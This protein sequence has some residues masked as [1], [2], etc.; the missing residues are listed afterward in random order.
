MRSDRLIHTFSIVACDPQTGEIGVAVASKFLAVGSIVPW[1]KANVGAVAT[2]S[3][4]NTGFGPDGL[5][6]LAEGKTA[7]ETLELLLE[8]D[9]DRDYRQVGIV[10][11][12]GN[13][14]AFTGKK[15]HDYAFHHIGEGFTCQGNLLAGPEVLD[16]MAI[17]FQYAKGD[18]ADRLLAALIA[19][20]EAGGD[21]RG[22][23]GAALYVVKE[24]GAYD[25]HIDRYVDLRVDD[26]SSPT[27]E[28]KRLLNLHRLYMGE[29]D[30][31]KLRPI[32]GEVL[33]ELVGHLTRFD[34]LKA[35][36]EFTSYDETVKKALQDY[37][38]VENFDTRWREDGQI[39]EEILAFMRTK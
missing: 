19:G 13:A 6:L 29:T 35:D 8:G 38:A 21:K 23:Q 25:G 9:E 33:V 20:D 32:E 16:A 34:F 22:K 30:P 5:K 18:L 2:Q 39:D 37:C 3:W 4:A 12:H 17:S 7:R 1:A 15:C 31:S 26:H 10:D 36:S 24:K 14:A 28:L 27:Y 11:R